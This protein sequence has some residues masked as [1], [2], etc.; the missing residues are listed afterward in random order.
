MDSLDLLLAVAVVW[1]VCKASSGQIFQQLAFKNLGQ[2]SHQIYLTEPGISHG[3]EGRVYNAG[4]G[5][6]DLAGSSYGNSHNVQYS[7]QV[8]SGVSSYGNSQGVIYNPQ[9]LVQSGV[10][11]Y[12]NSLDAMYNPQVDSGVASYG[13]LQAGSGITS[14][15]NAQGLAYNSQRN[16]V[17]SPYGNSQSVVYNPGYDLNQLSL[18]SYGGSQS[19]QYNTHPSYGVSQPAVASYSDTQNGQYNMES[20]YD[21]VQPEPSAAG[22]SQ[23]DQYVH[24]V[25]ASNQEQ[26]EKSQKVSHSYE[27][28]G[29]EE[30]KKIIHHVS[31]D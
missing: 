2:P 13:N 28:Q 22:N 26:P 20:S 8:E 19:V 4:Y 7:P 5:L 31:C 12:G 11:S 6:T 25:H 29:E 16:S 10:L 1:A 21:A 30:P 9:D 17:V 27:K 18:S 24:A 3:N 15:G 23:N 14:Y